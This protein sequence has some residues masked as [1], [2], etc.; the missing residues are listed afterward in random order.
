MTQT[1]EAEHPPG[2]PGREWET[3]ARERERQARSSCLAVA[4]K[5]LPLPCCDRRK[6]WWAGALGPPASR[7]SHWGWPCELAALE[8]EILFHG[9]S[10]TLP[11]QGESF[12]RPSAA[13]YPMGPEW[14]PPMC[15]PADRRGNARGSMPTRNCHLAT[16][17]TGTLL[18]AKRQMPDV[19]TPAHCLA[20]W[21]EVSGCGPTE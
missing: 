16:K 1:L 14:Q 8:G 20:K 4:S 17:R 19:K 11:Q 3:E 21:D 2:G 9:L 15:P 18:Q 10:H 7:H 12:T 13:S 5:K 6:H